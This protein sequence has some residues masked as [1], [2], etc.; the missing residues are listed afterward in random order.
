MQR[1]FDYLWNLPDN[2]AIRLSIIAY[3]SAI[4]MMLT[5]GIIALVSVV[6]SACT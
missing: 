6:V 4:L 1:L 3:G 2:W 5:V